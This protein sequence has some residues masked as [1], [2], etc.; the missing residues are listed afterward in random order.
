MLL[1]VLL[2]AQASPFACTFASALAGEKCTYEGDGAEGDARA[3]SK[4]AAEAGLKACA[5]AARKDDALRKD[6]ENAVAEAA[7][8]PRCALAVRLADP[9]GAL[10]PD[11]AGCVEAVRVAVSRTS[12]AAAVALDCCKCLAAERCA[13]PASQCK[14]ELADLMPGA[15][16][17]KCLVKSCSDSCAFVVSPREPPA[18]KPDPIP[19][20]PPYKI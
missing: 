9:D 16:L 14:S 10:T 3:N 15:A 17:Q 5:A 8:G 6:C 20:D 12:R 13:V 19:L 2:V 4:L 18:A 1:A 7:L 11:A